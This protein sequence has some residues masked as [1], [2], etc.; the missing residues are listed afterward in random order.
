MQLRSVSFFL[1][2]FFL[3]G[4]ALEGA[5]SKARSTFSIQK[6]HDVSVIVN[7]F[8]LNPKVEGDVTDQALRGMIQ[9]LD[10]N[11]E[12]LTPFE[13][14][15]LE[16][17]AKGNFVG[18]GIALMQAGD[19]PEILRVFKNSPA[20]NSNLQVGDHILKI[21]EV[22]VDGMSLRRV[23][24]L[25]QGAPGSVVSLYVE[26]LGD[27]EDERS[28]LQMNLRRRNIIKPSVG[29]TFKN[30]EGV[31]YLQ[32][33][34][35]TDKSAHE[36]ETVLRNMESDR[37]KGVVLDLRDNAGGVFEAGID[38]AKLF[39]PLDVLVVSTRGKVDSENRVFHTLE[40]GPFVHLP[41]VLLVNNKTASAA[42][43]LAGAL[44]GNGRGILV[45]EKTFGKAS[46][47]TVFPMTDGSALLLTTAYYYTPDEKMI[48]GYG[49]TPQVT[50][51][52]RV[53]SESLEDLEED[54]VLNKA[55]ELF[56][57]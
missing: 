20:E 40:E 24:Q 53:L 46:I 45:G 50:L 9:E 49:L 48:H 43:V 10:K 51:G 2:F 44:S 14:S 25:L 38:V 3:A 13:Y 52:Q 42:E 4:S 8:Y 34:D 31:A 47:Q 11:S 26:R 29:I 6:V 36:I 19:A 35:F 16:I 22:D 5:E 17:E 30:D 54:S 15:Q 27:E 21:D 55:F 28:L 41:I 33:L 18:V 7:Q 39:L 56:Q 1:L 57:P 37:L 12:Y 32:C 23:V